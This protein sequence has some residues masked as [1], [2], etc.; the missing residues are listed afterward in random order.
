ME[1]V[2]ATDKEGNKLTGAQ[3]IAKAIINGAMKGSPEM[4]KIALSLTGET[5]KISDNELFEAVKV[6]I[7]V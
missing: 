1:E 6:I 2:V 7:D 5:P 4:V 3:A